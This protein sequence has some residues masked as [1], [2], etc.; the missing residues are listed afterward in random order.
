MFKKTDLNG[1]DMITYERSPEE[2][3][4]VWPDNMD[5]SSFR[6]KQATLILDKINTNV[7]KVQ[8]LLV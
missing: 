5:L 4:F 8:L 1:D 2:V 7:F 6:D 3:R